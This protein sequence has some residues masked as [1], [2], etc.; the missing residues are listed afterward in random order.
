MNQRPD[1]YGGRL[2]LDW[3]AGRANGKG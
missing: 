2:D 1:L 3:A